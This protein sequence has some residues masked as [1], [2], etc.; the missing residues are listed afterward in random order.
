MSTPEA[1]PHPTVAQ[2]YGEG[3]R[4]AYAGPK[5]GDCYHFTGLPKG[6]NQNNFNAWGL[7]ND[8]CWH[9]WNH[10]RMDWTLDLLYEGMKD[11]Y[12]ASIPSERERQLKDTIARA[13]SRLSGMEYN[14]MASRP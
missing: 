12:D 11:P 8:W 4:C 7:P 2:T 3:G 13:F 6:K 9:C 1:A 5:R 14:G 10:Y